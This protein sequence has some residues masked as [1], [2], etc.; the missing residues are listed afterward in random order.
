MCF[1]ACDANL[2][3]MHLSSLNILLGQINLFKDKETATGCTAVSPY[4]GLTD[5]IPVPP[6]PYDVGRIKKCLV[7]WAPVKTT[8]TSTGWPFTPSALSL[9]KLDSSQWGGGDHFIISWLTEENKRKTS[10]STSPTES[11]GE[12]V[13]QKLTEANILIV[14]FPRESPLLNQLLSGMLCQPDGGF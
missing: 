7:T 11:W 4:Q 12:G 9:N 6:C 13:T 2:K 10:P 3:K 14:G 8:R 5:G 1:T